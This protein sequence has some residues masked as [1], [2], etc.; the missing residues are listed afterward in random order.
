MLQKYY[1]ILGEVNSPLA[2]MAALNFTTSAAKVAIDG[3][4][5][6]VLES[7]LKDAVEETAVRKKEVETSASELEAARVMASKQTKELRYR[8]AMARKKARVVSAL[9]RRIKAVKRPVAGKTALKGLAGLSIESCRAK[10]AVAKAA[11]HSA[12]NSYN[13]ACAAVESAI[14]GGDT[15]AIRSAVAALKAAVRILEV[16]HIEFRFAREMLSIA[17]AR[18]SA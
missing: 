9:G 4:S 15:R 6:E 18:H 8:A 5:N 13:T 14:Q 1:P 10:A 12:V 11:V 17:L 2:M 7:L 3:I 16:R